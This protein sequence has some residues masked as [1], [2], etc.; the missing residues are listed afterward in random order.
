[1][2]IVFG[3][4]RSGIELEL[5]EIVLRKHESFESNFTKETSYFM[6]ACVSMADP[7]GRAV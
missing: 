6:D 5:S 1:V 7:N 2:D 4:A 3:C